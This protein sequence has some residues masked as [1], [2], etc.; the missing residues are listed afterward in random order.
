L[1]LSDEAIVLS[2]ASIRAFVDCIEGADSNQRKSITRRIFCISA[3]SAA[4]T[5][6]AL[7]RASAATGAGARVVPGTVRMVVATPAAIVTVGARRG[8]CTGG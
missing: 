6:N 5:D 1:G 7:G 4:G 3:G 2:Q 8:H